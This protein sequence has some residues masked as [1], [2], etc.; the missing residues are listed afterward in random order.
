MFVRCGGA[1]SGTVVCARLVGWEEGRVIEGAVMLLGGGLMSGRSSSRLENLGGSGA[2]KKC[3]ASTEPP[4]SIGVNILLD[5]EERCLGCGG[6]ACSGG[7]R[8]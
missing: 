8:D 2:P 7:L 3:C 6:L 1:N 5:L 4:S